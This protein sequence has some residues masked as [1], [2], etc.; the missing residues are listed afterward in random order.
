MKYDNNTM[1]PVHNL[2]ISCSPQASHWRMS[3]Y[4]IPSSFPFHLSPTSPS[5]FIQ[6]GAPPFP[7]PPLTSAVACERGETWRMR[8]RRRQLLRLMAQFK[9]RGKKGERE[10]KR[11]VV[12]VVAMELVER[13]VRW[14]VIEGWERGGGK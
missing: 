10:E 1:M 2:I 12:V 9:I 11:D 14:E 13:R 5:V 6:R 4:D 7:H 8:G 3:V